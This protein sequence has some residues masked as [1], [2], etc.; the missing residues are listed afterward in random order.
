VA[1]WLVAIATVVALIVAVIQLRLNRQLSAENFAQSLWTEYLKLGL[2]NP[3]LSQSWTAVKFLS[4]VNNYD[5]LAKGGTIGSERYLWFLTIML[6]TCEAILNYL[7]QDT[8]PQTVEVQIR[9]HRPVLQRIW[10]HVSPSGE[11]WARCY[12]AA[13]RG[14]VDRV[15]GEPAENSTR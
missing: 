13:F 2:Q 7:P 11:A 6:D 4:D 9:F 3:E 15:L 12:G 14:I 10:N 8:W 5:D 1:D